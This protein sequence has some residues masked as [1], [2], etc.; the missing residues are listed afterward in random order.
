MDK[1]LLGAMLLGKVCNE[2]D[3]RR[4]ISMRTTKRYRSIIYYRAMVVVLFR[5]E[6]KMSYQALGMEMRK[7]HAT[8]INAYKK[9]KELL[10][11][12]YDDAIKIYRDVKSIVSYCEVMMGMAT[13]QEVIISNKVM[14]YLDVMMS[15]E[16]MTKNKMSMIA[17]GLIL[18]ITDTYCS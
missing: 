17:Y 10:E 1:K 11:L 8:M 15:G 4:N 16:A 13:D 12:K 3:A 7:D 2:I 14:E 5:E 6:Y 18:K 9:G